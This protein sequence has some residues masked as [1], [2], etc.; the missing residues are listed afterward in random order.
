[1]C[2]YIGAVKEAITQDAFNNLYQCTHFMDDQ[3][4]DTD[5]EWEESLDTKLDPTI[6][7]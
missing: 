7:L 6:Q 2:V 1:M 5:T 3:E 4:I